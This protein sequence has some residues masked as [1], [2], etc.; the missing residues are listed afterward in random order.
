MNW[1]SLVLLFGNIGAFGHRCIRPVGTWLLR[2]RPGY[3]CI[4]RHQ[5]RGAS[6]PSMRP[7]ISEN[8]H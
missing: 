2:R 7:N 6:V 4:A 8:Q 5:Q 1:I 3:A